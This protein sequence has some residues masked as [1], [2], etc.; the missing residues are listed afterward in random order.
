MKNQVEKNMKKYM[1]NS[2]ALLSLVFLLFSFCTFDNPK[3]PS[4][5]VKIN[6]PLTDR[7]YTVA[8]LIEDE[9]EII[10]LENGLIGFRFEGTTDTV[11]V[12]DQLAM[13]TVN[14][15]FLYQMQDFEIPALV[16]AAQQYAFSQLTEEAST[17]NGSMDTISPFSFTD[18]NASYILDSDFRYAEIMFGKTI[19]TMINRLSV[20]LEN[21]IYKLYD[22]SAGEI[23]VVSEP[24]VFVAAHD[25]AETVV[26]LSEQAISN[27]FLWLMSGTSPGSEGE[28]INVD[29]NETVDLR[30]SMSD[31]SVGSIQ[32]RLPHLDLK[33]RESLQLSDSIDIAEAAIRSGE[34]VL[35]VSN[36]FDLGARLEVTLEEI[37]QDM[38]AQPA[39]LVFD[40]A[41]GESRT[42]TYDL[43]N[44]HIK[45]AT[46][47]NGSSQVLSVTI[48]MELLTEESE[49]TRVESGDR[50][51]TEATIQDVVFDYLSGR[52]FEQH[53]PLSTDDL[54]F[55]LPDQL[56][57]LQQAQ[58]HDARLDIFLHSTIAMP[59]RTELRFDGFKNGRSESF[60][61]RETVFAADGDGENVTPVS[62]TPENSNL[63]P[64]INLLPDRITTSG[65]VWVGDGAT[66]GQVRYDDYVFAN[67]RFD[68]SANLS[69]NEGTVHIDTSKI[70]IHPKDTNQD[71]DEEIEV[72]A[73]DA[74][75]T[76]H[77]IS[78]VFLARVK[79]HLPV[80]AG[81][82][83]YVAEDSTRLYTAPDLVLGPVA[84]KSAVTDDD[85]KVIQ[86]VDEELALSVSPSEMELFHN[87]SANEKTLYVAS[88]L[89]FAGTDGKPVLLFSSDFIQI[90]TLVK[91]DVRIKE[92]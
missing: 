29:Q 26:T 6:V 81:F 55:D 12:G 73:L 2:F 24:I 90:Q 80:G 58:I 7:T 67:Y 15:Q 38:D 42:V 84:V 14:G 79:N 45:L 53:V 22:P 57:D 4:W 9:S 1:Y 54:A 71:F 91:L 21:V 56:D 16:T 68:T 69:W 11:R 43:K 60:D 49:L 59:F 23:V 82:A 10:S 63:L 50:V 83:F 52:L 72:N 31:V 92:D 85:G 48:R 40:L 78:A 33:R 39:N 70:A 3:T 35:A 18:V 51:E 32:A 61:I 47:G 20:P 77:L 5:D 8:D 36:S 30:V 13:P 89:L 41:P 46:A 74:D 37:F 64:F 75:V 28:T 86:A 65:D 44:H 87:S 19:L 76:E 17:K 25:S 34:M 66:H 27:D 62:L 88:D